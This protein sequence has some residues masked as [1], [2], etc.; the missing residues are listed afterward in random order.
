MA[1]DLDEG[2]G[3]MSERHEPGDTA[4]GGLRFLV[5][6]IVGTLG[7][8]VAAAVLTY[9]LVLPLQV[10]FPSLGPRTVAWILTE[11]PYFPVQIL[12]GLLLGFQLGRRYRHRVM[13]WT[14]IAP[15]LAIAFMIL[16]VP[17]P[18]VVVSGVEITKIEHFFGW[19]C[20]PQNHCF[21]QVPLTLLFY[22]GAA[23]SFGAFFARAIP[24]PRSSK[25]TESARQAEGAGPPLRHHK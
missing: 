21:E 3:L 2:R 13:L 11:T 15:A 19:G 25:T 4:M 12:V 16:F 23:Y 10:F 24:G 17:L 6:L 8:G 1:E 7:V 22:A 9:S 14:W 18:P 20:L 5:H